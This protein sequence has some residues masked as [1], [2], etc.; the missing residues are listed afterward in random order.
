M[1]GGLLP[2]LSWIARWFNDAGPAAGSVQLPLGSR[3]AH[4]NAGAAGAAVRLLLFRPDADRSSCVPTVSVDEGAH[5]A[6]CGR[7]RTNLLFKRSNTSPCRLRSDADIELRSQ[8]APALTLREQVQ[9][10]RKMQPHQ[11]QEPSMLQDWH[12]SL[13]A[14]KRVASWTCDLPS[15]PF[16]WDHPCLQSAFGE[17]DDIHQWFFDEIISAS[18][19]LWEHL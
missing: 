15:W 8:K 2:W 19:A 12:G 11:R 14:P 16:R 7:L 6:F 5:V 4:W 1:L 13:I 10:V 18:K 9:P 3:E 17:F